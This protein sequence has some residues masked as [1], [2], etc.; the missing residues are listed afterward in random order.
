MN[1]H[2]TVLV[3]LFFLAVLLANNSH[4][5]S[6]PQIRKVPSSALFTAPVYFSNTSQTISLEL[7][8]VNNCLNLEAT[9]WLLS[10][11]LGTILAQQPIVDCSDKKQDF[12]QNPVK[13][14]F[15]FKAPQVKDES[16]FKWEFTSCQK[17]QSCQVL[18]SYDFSVL[19]DDLLEPIRIWSKKHI[20]YVND[21]SNMLSSFFDKNSIEYIESKR[22]I[23]NNEPLISLV[24][25]TMKSSEIDKLLP[26][27][28]S[29]PAI[30]FHEYPSDFPTIID[31]TNNKPP[32]IEV[33]LPVIGKLGTDAAA[34]KI[35][36]KLF[37]LLPQT[38]VIE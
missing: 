25:V 1:I 26:I 8:D 32:L 21:K 28:N 18:G 27:E 14:N 15:H 11:R 29:Q 22:L 37:Y 36:L 30:L 17:K 4:V 31:K 12:T 23:R 16:Q 38:I 7:T 35:F 19:P 24:V 3:R 6:A 33:Y 34:Q 9:L 2:I 13:L 20:L 5:L 10:T